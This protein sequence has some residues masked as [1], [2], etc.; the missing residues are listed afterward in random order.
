MYSPLRT[1]RCS[2]QFLDCPRDVALSPLPAAIGGTLL[3]W[4]AYKLLQTLPVP[5]QINSFTCGLRKNARLTF[6]RYFLSSET[7]PLWSAHSHVGIHIQSSSC[8]ERRGC[9]AFP[10]DATCQAAEGK[11]DFR[12]NS[13]WPVEH[14]QQAD[15][16]TGEITRCAFLGRLFLVSTRQG[17]HCTS[18]ICTLL[19]FFFFLKS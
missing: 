17:T 13:G 16:R 10:A 1:W 2:L 5:R 15:W 19:I 12:C 7:F 9:Y 11:W 6:S 14:K 3:P 4:D 18:F 8:G